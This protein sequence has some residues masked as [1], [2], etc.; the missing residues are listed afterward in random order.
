[1]DTFRERFES[2]AGRHLRPTAKADTAYTC[3]VKPLV[4]WGAHKLTM[5]DGRVLKIDSKYGDMRKLNQILRRAAAHV[6][7]MEMGKALRAEQPVKLNSKLTIWP[8]GI[9]VG[10]TEIPWSELDVKLKGSSADRLPQ[11]QSREIR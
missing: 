5:Q 8:G 9:E 7:G 1:M 10:K 4:Q 2:T 11:K 3:A 6:T